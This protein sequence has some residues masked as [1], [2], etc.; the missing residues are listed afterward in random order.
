M[1]D[2][3]NV[4]FLSNSTD[5]LGSQNINEGLPGMFSNTFINGVGNGIESEEV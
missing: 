1:Q 4:R 2:I 3:V 5:S